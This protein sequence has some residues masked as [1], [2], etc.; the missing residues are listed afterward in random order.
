MFFTL[1]MEDQVIFVV[2][3]IIADLAKMFRLT[4]V[5][6]CKEL[7]THTQTHRVKKTEAWL[8]FKDDR[9]DSRQQGGVTGYSSW[10]ILQY[11]LQGRSLFL[12]KEMRNFVKKIS[13]TSSSEWVH[14]KVQQRES[15]RQ[16]LSQLQSLKERTVRTF[17]TG[18]V[19]WSK[20]SEVSD[21][22]FGIKRD[23]VEETAVR[24]RVYHQV[25]S[26]Y[27]MVCCSHQQVFLTSVGA[28]FIQ[29]C[30]KMNREASADIDI[31]RLK[32]QPRCVFI[33]R[34]QHRV[35]SPETSRQMIKFY[36]VQILKDKLQQEDSKLK[37]WLG[38]IFSVKALEVNQVK[39]GKS[40][41]RSLHQKKCLRV[42]RSCDVETELKKSSAATVKGGA[43]GF[44]SVMLLCGHLRFR[45]WRMP[46]ENQ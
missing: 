43:Y 39:A 38:V 34:M 4:V 11:C 26:C 5:V 29:K 16:R 12:Q 36:L 3:G 17:K 37:K 19:E 41:C 18:T 46:K 20:Q 32:A 30:D 45:L 7:H 6:N 35:V 13:E 1:V 44:I 9:K 2:G 22:S 25:E 31:D 24:G 21:G 8:V 14:Q 10:V 27:Y 23:T 15:G 33:R 28:W 42:L 40:H